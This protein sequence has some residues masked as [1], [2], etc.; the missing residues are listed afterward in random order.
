MLL[1]NK[2]KLLRVII[3]MLILGSQT[4]AYKNF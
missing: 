3:E 2:V 1:T 4:M